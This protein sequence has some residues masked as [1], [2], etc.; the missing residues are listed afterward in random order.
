MFAGSYPPQLTRT[1]RERPIVA[2]ARDGKHHPDEE[3][4]FAAFGT[5]P[6]E[7]QIMIYEEAWPCEER[8]RISRVD[9]EEEHEVEAPVGLYV[10]KPSREATL[11]KYR[12]IGLACSLT[13]K[14]QEF[15]AEGDTLNVHA[16]FAFAEYQVR[17][18][19]FL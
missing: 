10:C 1:R 17:F 3:P 8:D 13:R 2:P 15:R 6:L 19:S 5:F 4:G 11:D 16:R 12:C 18:I 9:I 7:I 14:P